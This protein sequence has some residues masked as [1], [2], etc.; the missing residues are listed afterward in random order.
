M[1]AGAISA[2][3]SGSLPT[4]VEVPIIED[5]AQQA[6]GEAARVASEHTAASPAHGLDMPIFLVA[7]V[8]VAL[9]GL[10]L[11]VVAALRA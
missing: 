11:C 8:L 2:Q 7:A 4:A 3:G 9:L 6:A 5:P 1:H 10:G